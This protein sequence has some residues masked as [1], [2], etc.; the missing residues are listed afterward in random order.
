MKLSYLPALVFFLIVS[1][2]SYGEEFPYLYKGARPLGM[3]GAFT[4]ISDDANALFYNPAGLANIKVTTVSP[5]NLQM[6]SSQGAY[7][8]TKEALDIDPQNSKK[9]ATLLEKHIGVS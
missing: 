6:E 1:S 5:F 8:F 7:S 2:N 9:V 4:A 3:G